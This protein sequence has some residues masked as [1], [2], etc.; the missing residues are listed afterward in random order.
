MK[1]AENTAV[2]NVKS[3]TQKLGKQLEKNNEN[4]NKA[5]LSGKDGGLYSGGNN[6]VY[7]SEKD[8]AQESK[9]STERGR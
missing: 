7:M 5:L 1:S 2:D 9:S 6:G 4:G 3:H 8:I